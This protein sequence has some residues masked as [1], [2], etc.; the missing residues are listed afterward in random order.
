ML[1][2]IHEPPP[3][4]VVMRPG[5][6]A[7]LPEELTRL[8]IER[9]FMIMTP[10]QRAAA[11]TLAKQ[12]G[13]KLVGQ[14]DRVAMHVPVERAAAAAA[15]AKAAGADGCIAL[16][17]GSAIGFGKA[18]TLQLSLP[19]LAVP[20][21]Y[22]GSE[23]TD[24]LG[25]T[26]RGAKTTRRDP[27]LRP[28]TVLYDP[29]LTLSLPPALSAT[30]GLNALAH[31]VEGLYAIDGTPVTGLLAEAAITALARSLP[32]VAQAPGDLE[33]RAEALYG[34]WL[35]GSV[36]GTVAMALHHKLCHVLGG[37]FD[38]PHA[39]AH[40][41]ILPH[42]TA[43]NAAAAPAA[44]ARIAQAL[45]AESAAGGLFDLALR[46]QAPTRLAAL[47]MTEP[48]LDRAAD[49]AVQNPYA[50][51]A[52]LTREGIRALLDDA[53]FGRRPGGS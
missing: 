4:R 33:A 2:F 32:A 47:G 1:S 44:M 3:T 37:S 21:T 14:F 43:Y 20:T 40:A 41:V 13:A 7:A 22:A 31:A 45:G 25:M 48:D 27:A 38:L 6:L 39:E 50:N 24:I 8:G 34:A 10:S 17:G 16:G 36:L 46:L 35:A 12:L 19:V 42:A 51:P 5:A 53:F 30:S 11:A 26:E 18:L 52:P 9:A 49:L 28:K 15:A 29:E 23:V